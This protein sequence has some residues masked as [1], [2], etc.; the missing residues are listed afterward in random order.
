MDANEGETDTMTAFKI[1][2]KSLTLLYKASASQSKKSY[3]GGYQQALSDIYNHVNEQNSDVIRIKDLVEFI[4][5]KH[6]EASAEETI[7]ESPTQDLN[8]V[9]VQ[10]N[11]N[12]NLYA[13]NN[14]LKRRWN[15][16]SDDLLTKRFKNR[17]DIN[18]SD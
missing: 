2:A 3:Q 14:E 4:K 5:S 16:G 15:D 10:N 11:N 9:T 8:V 6:E 12:N 17:T 7:E 13:N 1:A 18:M